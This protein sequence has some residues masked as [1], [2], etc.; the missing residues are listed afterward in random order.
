[1][2]ALEAGMRVYEEDEAQRNS[3]VEN[4]GQNDRDQIQTFGSSPRCQLPDIGNLNSAQARTSPAAADAG[5]GAAPVGG[6]SIA[7]VHRASDDGGIDASNI[8]NSVTFLEP[9]GCVS[10]PVRDSSGAAAGSHSLSFPAVNQP[11]SAEPPLNV[12]PQVEPKLTP[13]AA[14][15]RV[16]RSLRPLVRPM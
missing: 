3:F 15:D 4:S 7:M 9:N 14:A 16:R 8:F 5:V 12:P 2:A 11:G 10:H 6:S 1:M 13:A